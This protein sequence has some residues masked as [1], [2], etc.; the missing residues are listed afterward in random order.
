MVRA[1]LL[2]QDYQVEEEPGGYRDNWDPAGNPRRQVNGS[3]AALTVLGLLCLLLVAGLVF[4]LAGSLMTLQASPASTALPAAAPSDGASS[5]SAGPAL[6]TPPQSGQAFMEETLFIGDSNFARLQVYG[7]VAEDQVIAELGIGVRQAAREAVITLPGSNQSRT[8]AQA[9]KVLNP[10]RI[11]VMLGTNDIGS[12]TVQSFAV[13]YEA[14]LVA[15]TG[16]CPDSHIV[17]AGIPPISS[18][19][20]Y[21]DFNASQIE[22]FNAAIRQVCDKL[23]LPYLDTHLALQGENGYCPGSYTD[24][25][26]LHLNEAA[27]RELLGYYTRMFVEEAEGE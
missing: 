14:F 1:G 16:A 7:L 21:V 5:G 24:T 13:S 19:T 18:E 8:M 11:L 2:P 12:Q 27:L 26:G 15:L 10:R 6:Y 9:A 25:D 3:G 17:V 20:S 22:P 23:G 4:M